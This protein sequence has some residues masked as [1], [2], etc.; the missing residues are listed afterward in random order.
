[1]LA[2]TLCGCAAVP[3]AA[4]P[5]LATPLAWDGPGAAESAQDISA[6]EFWAGF[7]N[8]Q[9]QELL[10]QA[11]LANP[12]LLIA[13]DHLLIARDSAGVARAQRQPSLSLNAGPVDTAATAVA[14][15]SARRQA[16]FEL[17]LDASYELDFWNRLGSLTDSAL[18]EVDA[19]TC[20]AETARIGLMSAVAQAYFD[21]AQA[22]EAGALMQRRL[23][24]AEE[25]LALQA[26]RRAAGRIDGAAIAEAQGS[27]ENVRVQEDQ[28]RWQRRAD[29]ARLALLLGR[30]PEGFALTVGPLRQQVRMPP[31]P[32]GL[33]STLLQRRPDLR[34][35]EARLTAAQARIAAT[36]AE[37]FP[38]IRLTAQFGVATDVLHR[39][40][41]GAVG[42]FGFGPEVHLPIFD[43]GA[44]AA[45]LDA[46]QREADIR[47]LEYR[48]A[49]LAAF[50]DVEKALLM[51]DA[52]RALQ[53]HAAVLTTRDAESV[54]V[55]SSQLEA[56]RKSRLDLIAAEEQG[57]DI[58]LLAL[59]S[60]R[61]QLDSLLALFQALG[62]GWRP[63]E[64]SNPS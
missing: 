36:W 16:V 1:M 20:D 27:I 11:A 41:S 28:W 14:D 21:L 13:A 63:A 59:D 39:A 35:A 10:Q 5:V 2:T 12:D 47:L 17:A 51:R 42:L 18:A 43:G 26:A 44:R 45:Q 53:R 22:D 62:G 19:F 23:A 38:Q 6:A 29:E 30:L 25:R 48:K 55:M 56:G 9:L 24:L 58:E 52:A 50:A 34:A 54:R 37:Q 33:P 61:A 64:E 4:P 7:G 8:A 57:L 31:V 49:A 15:G 32:A 3:V 46:S 60:Y 40:A